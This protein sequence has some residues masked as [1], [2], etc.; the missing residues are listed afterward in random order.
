MIK[1]L[2]K[3]LALFFAAVI[4]LSVLPV[5]ASA[6]YYVEN[7]LVGVDGN[8]RMLRWN[9]G[10]YTGYVNNSGLPNDSR[11]SARL[12]YTN[13]LS[14]YIYTYAY[15]DNTATYFVGCFENGFNKGWG[16]RH[17]KYGDYLSGTWKGAWKDAYYSDKLLFNGYYYSTSG[18]SYKCYGEATSETSGM[19]YYMF[20][21]SFN[22]NGGSGAPGTIEQNSYQQTLTIPADKPTRTGYTFL[23]W[24]TSS[25]ASSASYQPGGSITPG[26]HTTLYAVWK[27]NTYT[28]SYNANGGS[29]APSNQTKT[30][31]KNL[32]L[33]SVKPSKAGY[34]FKNWNTNSGGTG[35]SYASGGTYSANASV[36]LY[37]QWTINTYPVSYNANG[38]S[39]P[40]S[41]Q[42]KTYGTNLTLSTV[43]P[44]RAGYSFKNWNTKAD[45]TGTSY[46]PGATYSTNAS[47][48]LYAQ[49]NPTYT[50]TYNNNGG[51]GTIPSQTK[52]H[53][54]NLT[55][56]T[57]IPSRTGYTFKSW[58]TKAD[59]SGTSYASGATYTANASVTLYAQWTANTYTITFR[60]GS[61]NNNAV[62]KTISQKYDTAVTVPADPEVTGYAFTGW[63][64]DIPAKMPANNMTVRALWAA[65]AYTITYKLDG[66]DYYE[67]PYTSAVDTALYGSMVV[68]RNKPVKEGYSVSDWEFTPPLEN[69]KMPSGNVVANAVSSINSYTLT[70]DYIMSDGKNELAPTSYIKK[71]TYN[72]PYNVVSPAVYGY[73]PDVAVVGGRMGAKNLKVVVNYMPNPHTVT[74]IND[75]EKDVDNYVYGDEI[76][77]PAD[78]EKEG[79]TF[80]GW[81]ED[82]ENVIEPEKTVPD[83]DIEYIAVWK[84]NRY[85]ITYYVDGIMYARKV[86]DYDAPVK[87]LAVPAKQGYV[88]SG[89]DKEEPERMPAEDIVLRGS[90]IPAKDTKY[91][92]ETYIM[93]LS[94][95]YDKTSEEFTGTTG[96]T[97]T[98][99]YTVPEGFSLNSKKSVLTGLIAPDGSL[100][101]KVY[102]DRNRHTISFNDGEEK[103]SEELYFGEDINEPDDPEKE[104]YSF[105]GWSEDGEN[106]VEVEE[107]VPDRDIEYI[108]V[109]NINK[110]TITYNI[111]GKK[112]SEK[113]Y[114]YN[115]DVSKLP[116]PAKQG[117]VFSGW[118]K[119]EPVKMPAE[120]LVINGSFRPATDTKYTVE[121]YI[122][123]LNGKYN[124]TSKVFAGTTGE[125]AKAGYTVNEGFN[126]N[127]EKSILTGV[128]APDGSLI[129]KVYLDRNR[130]TVT[131]NDGT[132]TLIEE[133]LYGADIDQ[134]DDPEKEGYIF[135]GWSE[136]GENAVEVEE[137][138]PDRDI[139]YYAVWTPDKYQIT[140]K[141]DG[142]EYFAT[143]Y[144]SAVDTVFYGDTVTI[145]EKAVKEG[146]TVS[147]WE[148]TPALKDGK[149][150][151]GN[152]TANAVS[153]INTYTV[154]WIVNGNSRVDSYTFGAKIVKPADP[155][156]TGK[157]FMGWS[158]EIPEK[159]PARNLVFVASFESITHTATF[160]V[161]DKDGS[162][163]DETGTY[164]VVKVVV[165]EEG[166]TAIAEPAVP[167]K[168]GY[169]G[170]WEDYTLGTT[171]I[172]IKAIYTI[173]DSD[174][175]GEIETEKTAD[176]NGG[177]SVTI[178]LNAF[179]DAQSI[180]VEGENEPLDIVL[181]VDQSGSMAYKMGKDEN[182]SAGQRRRDYLVNTATS[183]VNSVKQNAEQTGADHRLSIVGFAMGSQAASGIGAYENTEVLTTKNDIP[184]KY[185]KANEAVYKNSLMSVTS[186]YT[187][188]TKAINNIE[189]KGATAADL[190]FDMAAKVFAENVSDRK[191]VIIF[192]TD[193]VPTTTN[194]F[195]DGVANKA[196]ISSKYLKA[197]GVTVYSIAISN[198]ANPDGTS[199][200]F[201]RFLHAAS[202]NYKDASS[203]WHL[204]ERTNNGYFLSVNDADAL[205]K[206]FD[207]IYIRTVAKTL[208]FGAVT[209]YDTVRKEFTMTTPQETAFRE[210]TTAKYG[211][212]NSDITVD[213]RT[214][215]T[216]YIEVRNITPYPYFDSTNVMQGWKADISF[217]V[218][219]NEYALNAGDYLTNT[220]EAGVTVGGC[221]VATFVSPDANIPSDRCI[222]EFVIGN[223]TYEIREMSIGDL[224][225][226]PECAYASWNIP[227]GTKV[228]GKV[229]K[230]YADYGKKERTVTWHIGDKTVTQSYATGEKITAPQVNEDERVFTGWS[231]NIE[232]HMGFS[233]LE[234]TAVFSGHTHNFRKT[235]SFGLCTD[236]RT[237]TYTCSCGACYT[238]KAAVCEHRLESTV[239]ESGEKTI[240]HIFCRDCPYSEDKVLGFRT[241]NT[242]NYGWYNNS[243]VV[244]FDLHNDVNG[245]ET[246]KLDENKYIYIRVPVTS[247][248]ATCQQALKQGKDINIIHYL[249]NGN[250]EKCAYAPDGDYII[251]RCTSFSY[252][253]FTSS[254]ID[255]SVT[256]AKLDCLFDGHQF[257]LTENKDGSKTEICSH[258][259]EK[260]ITKPADK[261]PEEETK[262]DSG[263]KL[264][265]GFKEQTAAYKTI[266]TVS[267]ALKNIPSAAKVYIG[268][269]EASVKNNVYSAEIGQ[270]SSTK[271]VKLEVKQGDKNLDETSLTIK[272]GTGFFS[273]LISFFKNF[274]FNM[275]KWRKVTVSF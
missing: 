233:D 249:D 94:G 26:N 93:N 182:A 66:A 176:E 75:G 36:T 39:N 3:A 35:T 149:M 84:I 272:V 8:G 71:I 201:D 153:A 82:G 59:G 10:Y 195:D 192:L 232:S 231:P 241:A 193:G 267:V 31:G 196:I 140:Y 261:K 191:K 104:G 257:K 60:Y 190:G 40:P 51:T 24:S 112:Y 86:C 21:V 269:K 187:H 44:T 200:N 160:V 206:I 211:I 49:W 166:Q 83:E 178:T 70:V 116:A 13:H 5:T 236:G 62:Y 109:W 220:N 162:Y 163:T 52:V 88:F 29:G 228:S 198:K 113:E 67:A 225:T 208:N 4:M 50:I 72:A 152:V 173:K 61:I 73:T 42:T 238:E 105:G 158:G 145:R 258:C 215:G 139:D 38:G 37:A 171:D 7:K 130:H 14:P 185:N 213:R 55:L 242:N 126:L 188:I 41:G 251:V 81:S 224:I 175:T 92:V 247:L 170:K 103:T 240:T 100:V 168:E 156:L 234:Y 28:V 74:W 141:L 20:R 214:D 95:E 43:K 45:G 217:D 255:E 181:V 68:I 252:Y 262:P 274:I 63:D 202:S 203:I 123:N 6:D 111:D 210:K 223:E 25:S 46:S 18:V 47:V 69:G 250:T 243:T 189:A 19:F 212:T 218:T 2:T 87:K 132:D 260:G 273:K 137:T 96:E 205:Q 11:G 9:Y 155:K 34:S 90:F 1:K 17:F 244:S 58:N 134:P 107:T 147:D 53:G 16:E 167:E 248:D 209:L 77:K 115:A 129:L 264:P 263:Y 237:E 101:L 136:D 110:Y 124:K 22:A 131:F 118:D 57:T 54:T 169:S 239:Y 120:N 79:Y 204:D 207:N 216:T 80:T 246:H 221:N 76:V 122:M 102:L 164:E 15:D 30:Y 119:E 89:W 56:V 12:N 245:A 174:N 230:Y 275:F 135:G 23:G 33:S 143:P 235:A 108:A 128:I 138:V 184:V 197:Q 121:T 270:V 165:F 161:P 98:A 91:T 106:A 151:A 48:T 268:G 85:K 97:A 172:V 259:G 253:V 133:L 219:A 114:E 186:D 150:P 226:A 194:T 179:S 199:E 183:F 157:R 254:D 229:A 142:V 271:S 65:N 265:A 177:G 146:Y 180:L 227:E 78:P 117:Y 99:Q 266:V 127:S 222:V 154:T 159:M 64:T 27:A 125:T 256:G 32:T 148:F 144:E